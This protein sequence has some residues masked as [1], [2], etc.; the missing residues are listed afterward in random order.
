MT[1]FELRLSAAWSDALS[2]F[3]ARAGRLV[4]LTGAGISAESGIP[5]FR[6]AEGYWTIGSRNYV[7]QELATEAMFRRQPELVWSFY[8]D[9]IRTY[10]HA[11]PNPAHLSVADLESALGDRFQLITQNVDGLHLMAGNDPARVYQIHG[12]LRQAR[13]AEA[14]GKPPWPLPREALLTLSR[15]RDQPMSEVERSALRCPAC[16]GWARPHVLWFDEYYD[17]ENFHFDSSLRA[18]ERADL[19]LV[20]GTSGATN[21][22]NLIA[23]QAARQGS[24][25]FEVNPE[26]TRFTALAEGTG[27]GLLAGRATEVLPPLVPHLTGV[28]RPP[29]AAA[30]RAPKGPD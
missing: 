2:R 9:R 26:P 25:I 3:R 15:D 30:S 12:N 11:Q 19:L 17:E 8:L 14:C 1:A 27:G 22:P 4:V 10:R 20:V 16:G 18:A 6:G 28:P 5:T 7:A 29:H 21:L 23:Q 13:C 24:V